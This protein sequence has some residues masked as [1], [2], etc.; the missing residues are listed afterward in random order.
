MLFR[1]SR[2]DREPPP[3]VAAIKARRPKPHPSRK[4][5]RQRAERRFQRIRSNTLGA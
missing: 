5:L 4:R 3:V 2:E 1:H